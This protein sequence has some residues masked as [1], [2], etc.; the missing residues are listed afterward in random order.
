MGDWVKLKEVALNWSPHPVQDEVEFQFE[1][2]DELKISESGYG[3]IQF[4][5]IKF[6]QCSTG[7]KKFDWV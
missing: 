3:V 5:G 2:G 6:L 1:D 7:K 4:N